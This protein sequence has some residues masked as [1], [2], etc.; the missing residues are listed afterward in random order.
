MSENTEATSVEVVTMSDGREVS[1]AGKKK[2]IKNAAI[3]G[4]QVTVTLDFRNGE[5]RTFAIPANLMAQFAAHG[6]LQKLGDE[7][8]GLKDMDDAVLAVDELIGRLEKGEWSVKRTGD[9]LAGTSILARALVEHTGKTMAEIKE[10]LSGKSQSEKIALRNNAKIKP[11]VERLESE[12]ASKGANI[13][14]DAMLSEL[15]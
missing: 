15:A 11:I 7:I 1:F 14:T 2:L 5:A 6:A 10:F 13:D 9:G 8:A 3:E 12:K 4:D